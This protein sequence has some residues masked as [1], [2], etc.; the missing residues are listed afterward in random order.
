MYQG[1]NAHSGTVQAN[2]SLNIRQGSPFRTAP[3][4]GKAAPQ[5][6]LNVLGLGKGEMVSG[7]D[8]WYAGAQDTYFWSGGC[9][10]FVENPPNGPVAIAPLAVRRRTDGTILPLSDQ[11]L[12]NVFGRFTYTEGQKGNINVDQTWIQQ[13][14]VAFQTPLLADLGFP[15]IDLNRKAVLP[16][17]QAFAA[18]Q[19]AGL[20]SK[21]LSC[22]GTFVTRHKGHDPTRG[23]SSHSW[24]VSMDINAKWNAYGQIPAPLGAIGS[25]REFVSIFEALGFAWGGYFSHPYEDGMHFELARFDL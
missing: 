15:S 14:I 4:A 6:E 23:L 24:G 9:A 16:F 10:S 2:T 20:G 22:D 18:I 19:A 11:D 13:N 5:T 3:L 7:N 12:P 8:V 1:F 21:L 25:T 17:Q